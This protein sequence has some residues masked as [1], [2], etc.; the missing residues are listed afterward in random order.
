MKLR[1][2][3]GPVAALAIAM[4]ERFYMPRAPE[5]AAPPGRPKRSDRAP[6]IDWRLPERSVRK[7]SAIDA[8]AG[9][10]RMARLARIMKTGTISDAKRTQASRRLARLLSSK[11][12]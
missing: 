6:R 2:L 12:A 4:S 3:L 5:P 1:G 9:E 7:N 8:Y 11:F 10:R